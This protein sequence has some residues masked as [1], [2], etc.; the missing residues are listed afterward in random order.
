LLVS[1]LHLLWEDLKELDLLWEDLDLLWEDLRF[2]EEELDLL[3]LRTAFFSLS[4]VR[5]R[6]LTGAGD[7]PVG[8]LCSGQWT[9]GP[10]GGGDEN[11]GVRER[12]RE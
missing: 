11:E 10:T 5:D 12:L 6:D 9:V 7:T 1:E 4:C 3:F 8:V 2:E